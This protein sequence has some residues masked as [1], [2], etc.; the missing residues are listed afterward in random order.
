MAISLSEEEINDLLGGANEDDNEGKLLLQEF[1]RDSTAFA[2][3]VFEDE[4][5]TPENMAENTVA[6]SAQTK[7]E[8]SVQSPQIAEFQD[9]NFDAG[10]YIEITAEL[11]RTTRS[12]KEIMK[13]TRGHVIELDRS[14]KG[15]IDILVDGKFAAKGKVVVMGENFGIKITH[16]KDVFLH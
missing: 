11:G 3:A 9:F 16:I 7:E 15:A 12:I 2:E 10:A 1:D 4:A 13:F 14:A 8:K 5:K 6:N